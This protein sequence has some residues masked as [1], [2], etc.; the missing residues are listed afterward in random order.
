MLISAMTTES[1]FMF[2]FYFILVVYIKQDVTVRWYQV[3]FWSIIFFVLLVLFM[4]L[5]IFLFI[6]ISNLVDSIVF[7][8][9]QVF[10]CFCC[11]CWWCRYSFFWLILLLLSFWTV[12]GPGCDTGMLLF[13]IFIVVVVVLFIVI[14][15]V[16]VIDILLLVWGLCAG[17]RMWH[18]NAIRR[19]FLSRS[20]S[21]S[22]T[23][24]PC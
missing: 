10:V 4:L 15:S 17:A 1:F 8:Q 23:R 18:W 16:I 3:V 7:M 19:P 21:G 6:T 2:R 14:V 11:C 9:G 12:Q 5:F 20:T 13:C 24:G 22:T